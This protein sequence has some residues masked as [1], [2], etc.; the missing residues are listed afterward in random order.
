MLNFYFIQIKGSGV[1]TGGFTNREKSL[2]KLYFTLK[3]TKVLNK[4]NMCD[5][6]RI[7]EEINTVNAEVSK[8][9]NS[10]QKIER[11]IE[12][13]NVS[14]LEE[15]LTKLRGTL[16]VLKQAIEGKRTLARKLTVSLKANQAKIETLKNEL[17]Q[18]YSLD[19]L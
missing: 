5:V 18:V 8:N 19:F 7:Q 9:E 16:S 6:K 17:F 14:S 4:K 11:K 1:L 10:L 3:R 15:D 12:N 13:S 2:P